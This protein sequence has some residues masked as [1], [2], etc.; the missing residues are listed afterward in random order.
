MR[1][2]P[3]TDFPSAKA[4]DRVDGEE[5]SGGSCQR[6]AHEETH[7]AGQQSVGLHWCDG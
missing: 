2:E 7:K 1:G 5:N 6:I 4:D 3:Y